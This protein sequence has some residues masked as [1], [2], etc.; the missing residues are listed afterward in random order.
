MQISRQ[1]IVYLTVATLLFLSIFSYFQFLEFRRYTRSVEHT[2]RVLNML[3]HQE[4]NITK[5]MALRR[6]Y[7]LS[8]SDTL[9]ELLF[10]TRTDI[11]G[12]MDS[13][14]T[15]MNG[16]DT[17]MAKL[18]EIR[19]KTPRHI[20]F[21]DDWFVSPTDTVS[22]DSMKTDIRIAMPALDDVIRTLEEMK[23]VE[24]DLLETRSFIQDDTGKL[25]PAVL[26]I[27][28][29]AAIGMLLFAFRMLSVELGERIKAR[30]TL[31]RNV[32]HLN[33]ANQELERFA[34]I[35]SHNLKEPLRKARTFIH[36]IQP[37][38]PA[39]SPIL[40]KLE[41]VGISMERLQMMLDDLLIYTRLQHHNELKERMD[42]GKIIRGVMEEYREQLDALGAKVEIGELPEMEIYRLQVVLVFRH[43]FS[44]SLKYRSLTAP[45]LIRISC[46]YNSV[47]GHQ[48]VGFSDNGIG[49][50]PAFKHKIFEVFGRLHSKDQYEGTGIGLAICRRVMTNHNGHILAEG[51]PGNGTVIS[52]YFPV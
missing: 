23:R 40:P 22:L 48:V 30:D 2:Y 32:E 34:F 4:S 10:A 16:H 42:P 6:G 12:T 9:K 51:L 25:L 43:L 26:L 19:E 13:L 38:I 8:P 27:S 29:L 50:D 49:F 7:V 5:L 47:S 28:G 21:S 31:A 37:E 39:G 24:R 1:S 18:V 15:L 35:A 20:L 45:P 44:N 36:R 11:L 17:Q 14:E 33:L 46:V 41:K 52:L 3:E